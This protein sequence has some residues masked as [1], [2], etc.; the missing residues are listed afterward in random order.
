LLAAAVERAAFAIVAEPPG[1]SEVQPGAMV[2]EIKPTLSNKGN[3]SSTPS[4]PR[5]RLGTS[6][7][8]IEGR[9]A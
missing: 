6:L 5:A 4:A 1:R 3:A 2:R 9:A 7:H 8:T